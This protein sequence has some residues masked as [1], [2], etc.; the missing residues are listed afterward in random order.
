MRKLYIVKSIVDFESGKNKFL[1][2]LQSRDFTLVLPYDGATLPEANFN[3]DE[4]YRPKDSKFA[5][6]FTQEYAQI[7]FHNM[8][9]NEARGRKR[10]QSQS[11][12]ENL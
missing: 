3:K 11:F 1:I 5:P 10:M 2:V 12:D 8:H 6:D 7:L 4:S 9:K